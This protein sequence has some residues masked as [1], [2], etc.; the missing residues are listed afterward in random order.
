MENKRPDWVKGPDDVVWWPDPKFN[1]TQLDVTAV[2]Y[3]CPCGFETF[4]I[5]EIGD[6]QFWGHAAN[7][8]PDITCQES[9]VWDSDRWCLRT[10]N[11]EG[12]HWT[13][14]I[15]GGIEW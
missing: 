6:H 8:N 14:T 15:D 12:K 13:P 4:S 3:I 1:P 7:R 9:P 2:K 11:H 10:K 5:K